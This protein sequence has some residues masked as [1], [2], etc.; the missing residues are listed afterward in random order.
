MKKSLLI[1]LLA[2]FTNAVFAQ[3]NIDP[4]AKAILDKAVQTLQRSAGIT[5]DFQITMEAGQSDQKQTLNGSLWLKNSKFKLVI[6]GVETYF[7]GITQWVYITEANEVTISNPTTAELQEINPALLLASYKKDYKIQYEDERQEKGKT[8]HSIN[9]YPTDIKKDF[10]RINIKIEK[11]TH[12]LFSIRTY[13]KSGSSTHIALTKYQTTA[14]DDS[15]FTF[16]STA[17]IDEIDLR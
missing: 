7:D 13:D 6:P 12:N 15:V 10:F 2:L 8:I 5:A 1:L 3:Q 4:K 14:L 9:L 11:D 16:N 17:E